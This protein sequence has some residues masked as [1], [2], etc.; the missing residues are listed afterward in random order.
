[1]IH[2]LNNL[3]KEYDVILDGLVNCFT[4]SR[5]DTLTIVVICK[6]LNHWCKKIKVK[7]KKE[8]KKEKPSEPIRSSISKGSI[9]VVSMVTNLVIVNIH[10]I[11]KPVLVTMSYEGLDDEGSKL[12]LWL[13]KLI[14]I[15]KV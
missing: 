4:A 2:V 11:E 7:M 3:S 14:I 8:E 13:I 6:N 9:S 12:F 1:M 10:K 5:D 15:T